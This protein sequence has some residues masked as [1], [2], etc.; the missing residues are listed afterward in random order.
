M[1]PLFLAFMIALLPLRGWVGDV[2]ALEMTS[3][4]PVAMQN[5]ATAA[6]STGARGIF[7]IN[8]GYN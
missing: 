3:G 1:R 8:S 5:I 7:R 6:Y 2:M 4:Q